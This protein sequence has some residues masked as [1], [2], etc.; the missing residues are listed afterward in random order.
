MDRARLQRI[1][2]FQSSEWYAALIVRPLTILVMLVI[3]DW[4]W[5]T[6]NWLTTLG[7]LCKLGGAA[8]MLKPSAWIWAALLLQL[9]VLFDH[10]DG[11][12]A[13][14]RRTFTRLGSFYDKVSDMVTW[15]LIMLAAGWM[16]YQRTGHAYYLLL[17]AGSATAL[18]VCGYMKWLVQAETERLRWMEA[19]A[20][21]AAAVAR[22]TGPI[23]IAPP[24]QRT[25]R[26][27][28]VWFA[29]MVS[30]VWR[31]EE[32]DLW[33]WLGLAL[34]IDRLDWALWLMFGSQV[35]NMIIMIVIRTRDVV[36]T[37]R[38]LQQLED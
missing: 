22:R 3:A 34:V 37:D 29:T 23:V 30:R 11:T 13:R 9:G 35:I 1:R 20:D 36:R 25:P 5:L 21:P 38:R 8:L 32:V 16:V 15:A 19:K 33:F 14:Y 12:V 31:F 26:Q 4:R 24:P 18:N 17:A 2:N 27:W 10:L 6:P 7:N 28:A